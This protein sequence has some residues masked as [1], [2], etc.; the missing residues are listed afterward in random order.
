MVTSNVFNCKYFW[1]KLF[2]AFFTAIIVIA[3]ISKL[4]IVVVGPNLS[5]IMWHV[6]DPWRLISCS[7]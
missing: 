6:L 3:E 7:S 2:V 1:Y 5:V 4:F